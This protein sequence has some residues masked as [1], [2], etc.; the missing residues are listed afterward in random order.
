MN[1]RT[2]QTIYEQILSLNADN[3]PVSSATFSYVLY[4]SGSTYTATTV[5]IALSDAY[6]GMFTASWNFDSTGIYQLYVKNLSTNV[7]F[8]SDVYNVRP[9][10]E[11]EQN[12]YIGL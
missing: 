3:V 12:I 7:V 2:G 10:S 8:V 9:D 1:Y 5:N 11:F 6:T 4:K